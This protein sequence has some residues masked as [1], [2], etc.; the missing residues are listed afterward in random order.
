[1]MSCHEK[2]QEALSLK[3]KEEIERMEKEHNQIMEMEKSIFR[4]VTLAK[5]ADSVKFSKVSQ[6]L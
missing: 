6:R 3:H 5:K 4:K 2:E 1:L